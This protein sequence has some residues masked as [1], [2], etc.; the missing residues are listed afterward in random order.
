MEKY[1]LVLHNIDSNYFHF[2]ANSNLK[3]I[4]K[5]G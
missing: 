3:S 1:Q 5:K 2:T 4:E